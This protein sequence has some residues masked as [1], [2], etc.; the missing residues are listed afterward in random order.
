M[1]F[2]I[3]IILL[4]SIILIGS[5][6]NKG[7]KNFIDEQMQSVNDISDMQV[8]LLMSDTY[9]DKIA[10][11]SL[12]S[13]LKDWDKSLWDLG[14]KLE[15]YR[16]ASEEFSKDEYY[17]EQKKQFNEKQQ[18]YLI[19]LTKIKSD[20]NLNKTIITFFFQNSKDCNKCDDQSYILTDI[21]RKAGDDVAIFSFDADLNITN[22]NLLMEYYGVNEFP[23]IIINEKKYCGIQD[24]N[25]IV[26][27]ICKD[28][29]V[30][31][32]CN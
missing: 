27:K 17:L 12:K 7:R 23:C 6:L 4:L 5:V 8:Y 26:E 11:L 31:E 15:Q 13:K 18:L 32:L 28:T 22:I 16:I 3:T 14:N 20:C 30:P 21:K 9:G 10:C 1:A 2:L 24:R 29:P 25:F 19:F